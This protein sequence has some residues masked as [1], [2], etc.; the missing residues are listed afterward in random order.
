MLN[1]DLGVGCSGN[2]SGC[3]QDGRCPGQPDFCIKRN[4]TRPVFKMAISD[5]E[6]AIDLTEDGLILE[7]SMWFNAKLKSNLD[8]SNTTIQFA[9]NLGFNQ[10]LVG[11]TIVTGRPRNP[12][13]MVVIA[14]NESE[15]SIDVERGQYGTIAQSWD[16]GTD[17]KVFRF[18]DEPA[19]IESLFEETTSLEGV[20]SEE[21][22]ET[23]FVFNWTSEQTS[24]PGCYWIEFKLTKISSA[25]GV[26]ATDWVKRFP[27]S[28]GWMISVID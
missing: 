26:E 17:L 27:M 5:C 13:K 14:I 7:A 16:R 19:E 18:I 23:F 15:K 9:D 25:P 20:V 6:G 4:D 12:E 1:A 24:M 8:D 11:D 10:I 2:T 21:L 28:E 3:N 22:V